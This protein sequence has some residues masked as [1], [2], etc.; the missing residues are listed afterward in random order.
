MTAQIFVFGQGPVAASAALTARLLGFA[1]Q[2]VARPAPA[3]AAADLRAWALRPASLDLLR[4]LGLPLATSCPVT[5]MEVWQADAAGTRLPG[6]L[7]FAGN[8]L[9][10]IVPAGPLQEELQAA[11]KRAAVGQAVADLQDPL[12]YMQAAVPKGASL[13]LICDPAWAAQLPPAVQPQ[14]S[15]WT[16]DHIALTAPVTLAKPHDH[17]AR[18][19]FLPSGPL[20]LLPLPDPRA[21]ALVWSLTQDKAAA[22]ARDDLGG[23]ISSLIGVALELDAAALGSFVLRSRQALAYVGQGFALVGEAAHQIHPL[24]GQGLNLAL[25]DLGTLFDVLVAARALGSDLRSPLTLKDYERRRRPSN[26]AMRAATDQLKRLFGATWGPV[27]LVRSLGLMAF[28]ASPLKAQLQAWISDRRPLC[29]ALPR[30]GNAP[31]RAA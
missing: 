21:A 11:L 4:Q 31:A 14:F 8:R 12:A 18:Q 24:A 15:A 7:N 23:H 1:V 9:G 30:T 16:Y 19:L 10:T 20:A 3:S 5:T 17:L 27:R 25:A 22:R 26:E 6:Q 29:Q 28:D 13:A 2:L